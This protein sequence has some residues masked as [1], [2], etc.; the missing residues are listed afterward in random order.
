MPAAGGGDGDR[1]EAWAGLTQHGLP[2]AWAT[3]P[4]LALP[5][6]CPCPVA[7]RLP[8]CPQ[9]WLAGQGGLPPAHLYVCGW[10]G[11]GPA[12]NY[13]KNI[14]MLWLSLLRCLD[15]VYPLPLGKSP[16]E[17]VKSWLGCFKELLSPQLWE[18]WQKPVPPSSPCSL[19]WHGAETVLTYMREAR[20]H[21]CQ[22]QGPP[23]ST[24]CV[25]PSRVHQSR[26]GASS[27][28]EPSPLCLS[29]PA[30]PA[31]MLSFLGIP[32]LVFCSLGLVLVDAQGCTPQV[33]TMICVFTL[34][35]LVSPLSALL[36][37]CFLF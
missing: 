9:Q 17:G 15:S 14:S 5:R 32:V 3:S 35:H 11:G 8:L 6:G 37:P 16:A 25:Q 12:P 24:E 10:E 7:G 36:S 28:S 1:G 23:C 4:S 20:L 13:I 22:K 34:G 29:S 19:A 30:Q 33:G 27:C 21:T 26:Q 2:R 31:N 18:G